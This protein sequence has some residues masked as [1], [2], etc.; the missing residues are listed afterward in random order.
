MKKQKNV[1]FVRIRGRIVPVKV[2]PGSGTK[3]PLAIQ[4]AKNKK[5][6]IGQGITS[7]G[8]VATALGVSTGLGFKVPKFSLK[9]RSKLFLVGSKKNNSFK[10]Q[11]KGSIKIKGKKLALL[12]FASTAIGGI[13][14]AIGDRQRSE[15]TRALRKQV[16]NEKQ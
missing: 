12:G 15:E 10:V 3:N 9:K 6:K 5:Q 2:K 11:R 7:S 16:R 1:R 4:A 14:S 13:M 8:L